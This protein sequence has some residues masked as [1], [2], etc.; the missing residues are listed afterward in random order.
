MEYQ[1]TPNEISEFNEAGQVRIMAALK[2]LLISTYF[3]FFLLE[4]K[5][6]R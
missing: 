6:L 1:N 4:F 2:V 3:H 5:F